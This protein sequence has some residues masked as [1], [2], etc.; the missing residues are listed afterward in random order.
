MFSVG[1]V[2]L[3]FSGQDFSG[4]LRSSAE[5]AEEAAAQEAIDAYKAIALAG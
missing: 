2:S 5:L 4:E 3:A 1:E